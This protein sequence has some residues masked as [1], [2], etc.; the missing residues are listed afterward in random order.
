LEIPLEIVQKSVTIA[1]KNN[2]TVIFNPAPAQRLPDE[3]LRNIDIITPNESEA[4]ILT[5]IKIDSRENIENA[6]N[7]LKNKGIKQVIITLGKDGV[8]YNDSDKIVYKTVPEV[9]VVDTT[10]AGDSFTGALAVKISE[11]ASVGE[12]I[13]FSNIVG[14][15]T[16]MKRGA[17]AS[18][19]SLKDV[20]SFAIS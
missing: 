5:G 19:P 11:G 12:A 18:L 1:K 10:A 9:S 2:V 16:V 8:A 20:N 17:Q 13:D 14:T 3:L 4:E 6:I 15:L 7:I